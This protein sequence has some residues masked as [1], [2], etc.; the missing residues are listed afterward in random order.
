MFNNHDVWNIRKFIHSIYHS[1]D[2]F[3]TN[4]PSKNTVHQQRTLTVRWQPLLTGIVKLNVDGSFS[5]QTSRMGSGGL[6]RNNVGEWI[7]GF[8]S[9]DGSGGVLLAELMDSIMVFP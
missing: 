6:I 9:S 5:E 3:V 4:Y 7:A 8:S 1:H 2:D